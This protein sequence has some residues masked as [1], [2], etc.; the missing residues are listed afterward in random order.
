M[1]T[2]VLLVGSFVLFLPIWVVWDIA[3][4]PFFN[5]FYCEW[6]NGRFVCQGHNVQR[7]LFHYS[8]FWKAIRGWWMKI[9]FLLTGAFAWGYI[10]YVIV[11]TINIAVQR[12]GDR[13][14]CDPY[15]G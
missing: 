2:L 3:L 12:L 1:K 15:L 6:E 14:T 11:L 9:W 13:L 4:P 8:C 7:C 10:L 5:H